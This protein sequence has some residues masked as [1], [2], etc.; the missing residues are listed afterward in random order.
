[1]EEA[2]KGIAKNYAF[3][4]EFFIFLLKYR[5][6]FGVQGAIF[7]NLLFFPKYG[8]FENF[9]KIHKIK[10]HFLVGGILLSS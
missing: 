5:V 3:L 7:A 2:K 10:S 8:L 9:Y 6:N 4:P 1:M